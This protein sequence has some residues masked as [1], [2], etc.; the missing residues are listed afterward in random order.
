[1]M[2][3]LSKK[4][5]NN[6]QYF[7]IDNWQNELDLAKKLRFNG[8]E[9]IISDFSNPIFNNEFLRIIKKNLTKN[10]IA[11]SSVSMDLIMDKS[12]HEISN[13]DLGWLIKKLLFLQKKFKLPRISFPIEERARFRDKKQKIIAIKNLRQIISKLSLR[14][15]I[16]IETDLSVSNLRS[17]MK[18]KGLEKLGLLIDIGNIRANGFKIED[19]FKYFSDKIFGIHVKY[20]YK[21]LGKSKIIKKNFS[22]LKYVKTYLNK[23]KFLND[24][25]FQT[26]RSESN[27]ISDIKK[28]IKN[29]EKTTFIK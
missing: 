23:L 5:G 17:L 4:I 7:P 8:V 10:K 24:I 20:R 14:S 12:L 11:I 6:F 26:Y 16:C 21:K 15:K 3:R 18:A 25:T 22:E 29:Y 1:M 9:W 28:N 27:F 19:Y 2:G 13:L